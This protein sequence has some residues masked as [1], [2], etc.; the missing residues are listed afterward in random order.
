[1]HMYFCIKYA[2]NIVVNKNSSVFPILSCN[3]S[4]Y[5]S[6]LTRVTPLVFTFSF[7]YLLIYRLQVPMPVTIFILTSYISLWPDFFSFLMK[8]EIFWLIQLETQLNK[9]F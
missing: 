4:F 8:G 1:M 7:Y 3:S 9:S 5:Q 6:A 2:E